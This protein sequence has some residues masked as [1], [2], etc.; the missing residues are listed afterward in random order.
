MLFASTT[1]RLNVEAFPWLRHAARRGTRHRTRERTRA[2]L[3][4]QG[5]LLVSI[6]TLRPA[7]PAGGNRGRSRAARTLAVPSRRGARFPPVA[8]PRP[9]TDP[10]V[11]RA[12]RA[13]P[14]GPSAAPRSAT[15]PASR[16]WRPMERRV[17]HSTSLPCAASS[18]SRPPSSEPSSLVACSV[19][20]ATSLRSARRATLP[21][22]PRP[23]PRLRRPR[24]RRPPLPPRARGH[25]S[26]TP[27]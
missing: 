15:S 1:G 24:L 26:S 2:F 11:R 12:L 6:P 22:S 5:L 8:A 9:R 20:R 23:H 4:T 17:A 14:G 19:E 16:K 10:A 27:A 13:A 3:P 18:A 21:R 25:P 7:G